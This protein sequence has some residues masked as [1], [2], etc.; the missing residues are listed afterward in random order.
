MAIPWQT[1][2]GL[3]TRSGVHSCSGCLIYTDFTAPHTRENIYDDDCMW[4]SIGKMIFIPFCVTHTVILKIKNCQRYKNI[5][6]YITQYS[7]CIASLIS[8]DWPLILWNRRTIGVCVMCHG[9]DQGLVLPPRIAPVQVVIVPVVTKKVRIGFRRMICV[10]FDVIR[11]YIN[12]HGCC[13][14]W[15]SPSYLDHLSSCN[16][17]PITWMGVSCLHDLMIV[18]KVGFFGILSRNILWEKGLR[19]LCLFRWGRT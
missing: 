7:R 6:L 19:L 18:V 9:D 17:W 12:T 11:C 4:T 2:W 8:S 5:I 1:S 10:G 14:N 3:T 13:F 15:P 16:P